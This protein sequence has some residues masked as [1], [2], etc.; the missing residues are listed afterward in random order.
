LFKSL[1]GTKGKGSGA[2]FSP[3]H[4][5]KEGG[6]RRQ[7]T[8]FSDQDFKPYL[9]LMAEWCLNY[10]VEIWAYCLMSNHIHLIAVPETKDGLNPAVGEAH[11]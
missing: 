8:F 9:A 7:Q 2:G 4:Y 1:H 5:T 6:N 3:S 11:R 10:K